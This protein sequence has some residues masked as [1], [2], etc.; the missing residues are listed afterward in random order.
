[1][2]NKKKEK[3]MKYSV[4]FYTQQE[5]EES[6]HSHEKQKL[7]PKTEEVNMMACRILSLH[8]LNFTIINIKEKKNKTGEKVSEWLSPK[9]KYSS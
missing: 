6:G 1:M 5:N 9:T 7:F 2:K 8:L 3:E 4:Q